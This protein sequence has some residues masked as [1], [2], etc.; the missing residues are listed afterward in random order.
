[1]IKI[2]TFCFCAGL[3]FGLV[4]SAQVK[5][6]AENRDF[7]CESRRGIPVTV[8][9]TER[10]NKV[11]IRWVSTRRLFGN[12]TPQ[13]HC[14]QVSSNLQAAQDNQR[15]NNLISDKVNGQQVICVSD[16]PRGNCVDILI[17]LKPGSNAKKALI[18]LLDLRGIG[19]G[20]AIEEGEDKRI[21]IDFSMYLKRTPVE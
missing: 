18:E 17:T 12:L 20:K 7:F 16:K 10:G 19:D 13:K 8:A 14:E 4:L 21:N 6:K 9:R 3:A 15:L 1:M 2:R 11:I 5:S